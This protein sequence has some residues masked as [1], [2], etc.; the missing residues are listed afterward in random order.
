M[1][2]R[3]WSRGLLF[4]ITT[5]RWRNVRPNKMPSKNPVWQRM[6]NSLNHSLRKHLKWLCSRGLPSRNLSSQR[7]ALQV[8]LL[9]PYRKV[10]RLRLKLSMIWPIRS[11]TCTAH[12]KPSAIIQRSRAQISRHNSRTPSKNRHSR[13]SKMLMWRQLQQL[14]KLKRLLLLCK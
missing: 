5:P 3:Q 2:S 6:I 7:T 9:L 14:Q 8:K 12:N 1:Q 4:Y 11:T 10:S 13:L